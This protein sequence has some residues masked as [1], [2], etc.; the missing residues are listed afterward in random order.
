MKNRLPSSIS[1]QIKICI[2]CEGDE[3]Y[4]YLVRLKSLEM[5][6]S[7]YYIV[8][9][10]ADG[11][12]NIPARYQDKYQNGSFDLV[13]MFCDIDRKPYE[14][15]V[16]I[17]QK[18]DTFHGVK[19]AAER[20]LIYGNPC[21]MQ[22]IIQ[23]WREICLKSSAKKVNAPMIEECTGVTNYKARE[24]Q[25]E[26]IFKQVTKE[27]YSLMLARVKKMPDDDKLVGSSNF[28]KFMDCFVSEDIAWVNEIN[29]V[30]EE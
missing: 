20:V 11:N 19:G 10:N 28:G 17:K 29:K 14:Q 3:E 6:N 15:Y 5:W 7:Q 23:H 27:N 2:I 12:G 18:I 24:D 13:L 22:I 16:D 21:T 1:P 25:R 4:E 26:R 9:E 30:L 8:L